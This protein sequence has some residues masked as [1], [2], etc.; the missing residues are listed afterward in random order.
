M[1]LSP[2]W[3]CRPISGSRRRSGHKQTPM[4][5]WPFPRPTPLPSTKA[6]PASPPSYWARAWSTGTPTCSNSRQSSHQAGGPLTGLRHQ[7]VNNFR[8]IRGFGATAIFGERLPKN[9]KPLARA[10]VQIGVMIDC[11]HHAKKPQVSL[12]RSVIAWFR[13]NGFWARL[14]DM[15]A[16]QM[17][18]GYEDGA[19]FHIGRETASVRCVPD[20]ESEMARF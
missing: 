16:T 6:L 10:C 11:D 5:W 19:G 20:S 2:C 1:E 17:P 12:L 8:P 14:H 3:F 18:V 4:W 7:S 15:I 9:G 13:P